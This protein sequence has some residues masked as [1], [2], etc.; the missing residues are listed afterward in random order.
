MSIW[1]FQG[2]P[3]KFVVLDKK[4]ERTVACTSGYAEK[5]CSLITLV[6]KSNFILIVANQLIAVV[7]TIK[8]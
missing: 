5:Y 6:K 8:V 4:S 7:K 1:D 3:M 2:Y